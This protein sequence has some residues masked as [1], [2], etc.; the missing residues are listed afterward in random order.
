[1]NLLGDPDCIDSELLQLA[2]VADTAALCEMA[3]GF[4]DGRQLDELT[5]FCRR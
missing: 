5:V 1:V 3:A 4:V 2:T